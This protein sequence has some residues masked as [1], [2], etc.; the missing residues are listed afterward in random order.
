MLCLACSEFSSGYL[1]DACR[2]SIERGPVRSFGAGF[3]VVAA[4]GHRGAAKQLVH[5]MKYQGIV[6]AADV[7]GAAMTPYV[8]GDATRLVPVPRARLRRLQYGVDP[9]DLLV[10][11]IH[12]RTGIPHGR[13]LVGPWWWPRHAGRP[14]SER[15]QPPFRVIGAPDPGWVLVDDVVTSGGTMLAAAAATGWAVRL[16]ITATGAGTIN[17]TTPTESAS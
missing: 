13:Q 14:R 9:A 12:R 8:P 3:T 4:L 11:A 2:R 7:L 15:H 1:C 6:A 16:G 5:R 17:E 10:R